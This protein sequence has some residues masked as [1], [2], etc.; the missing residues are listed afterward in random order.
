MLSAARQRHAAAACR[1]CF[2]ATPLLRYVEESGDAML[3]VK[4]AMIIFFD[5]RRYHYHDVGAVAER[6]RYCLRVIR[7]YACCHVCALPLRC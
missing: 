3:Y 7:E 2:A 4:R 1:C 6:H 5:F